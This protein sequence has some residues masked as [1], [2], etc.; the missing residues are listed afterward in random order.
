MSKRV[1]IDTGVQEGS[2]ISMYYDPMIS[3]LITWGKDRTEALHLIDRAFDEYVIRGVT[4]NLGFGKS[5]V[6]NEDFIK[7]DY[8]TG[9]IEKF[10]NDGFTGD[11]LNAGD[12]RLLAVVGHQIKNIHSSYGKSEAANIK[13]LYVRVEKLRDE[14][15]S[16]YKI[17]RNS[18]EEFSITNMS[19]GKTETHRINDFKYEYN[20]LI[21]LNI[22]DE[23]QILQFNNAQNDN[24]RYGFNYK[25][26]NIELSVLDERQ[27]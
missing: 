26:N 12:H 6:H 2:E 7:G 18:D 9:F 25:G 3:K 1:R 23:A 20:S 16:D 4:H 13:T 15:S 14:P 21:T 10:Y 17:T 22:D 11:N 5:I 19:T 27:Y 8:S 24:I